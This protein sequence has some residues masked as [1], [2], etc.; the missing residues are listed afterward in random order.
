[1]AALNLTYLRGLLGDAWVD[2]EI[3]AEKPE[4]LL[5]RWQKKDENNP[6]VKYAEEL[7]AVIL[8]SPNIKLS[9]EVLAQKIKEDYVA[10][11]A[12]M[13]SAVFLAQQG[14]AVTLEPAAPQK[15]PD[16]R[17]DL[18]GNPYFVEIRTVGFSEE[19][20]RVNLVTKQVFAKLN[21]VPSCYFAAVT[22]SDECIPNSPQTKAAIDSLVEVLGVLKENKFKKATFY[23]A[24]PD[25]K[26]LNPGGDFYSTDL[27]DEVQKR[28]SDIVSKAEVVVRFDRLDE[29][30]KRTPA[31]VSP[32][33]KHP[34][35]P[36]NTHERLKKILNKK[37]NQLPKASRG[38]IVLEVSE[39]FM[40]D[41]FSIYAALYGDLIIEF[42]PVEAGQ[43]VGE[44]T[45]RRNNRGFF[46]H[47]SRVSAIVIQRRAVEAGR[48]KS[49]QTVYPT[50]RANA[51]TIRLSL[52][53]LKRFGDVGDRE[54]LSAENAPNHVDVDLEIEKDG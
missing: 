9:P 26:V 20:E 37:R 24:Y 54:N 47:T 38:I 12:E 34:P 10:T 8:T 49:Y 6:R 1:M 2:A 22:I 43:P 3:Y 52:A 15:G 25:G 44:P 46:R 45:T 14:F 31:S 23:Y 40:L 33:V 13:E 28:C 21:E 36:V 51:D 50:N 30:Q 19:E 18:E 7:V 11:L 39:Q 4:H 5:G 16:I 41:D 29:E 53:E 48:V 17:A 42:A 27:R 35:E 32:E